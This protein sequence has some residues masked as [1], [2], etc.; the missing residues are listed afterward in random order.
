[1]KLS[2]TSLS[3]FS[4]HKF[5]WFFISGCAR[6]T[7]LLIVIW[8]LLWVYESADVSYISSK[9]NNLCCA[10]RTAQIG[11][12][13]SNWILLFLTTEVFLV[14]IELG[15][16]SF[17]FW[18]ISWESSDGHGQE[19]WATRCYL[20]ERILGKTVLCKWLHVET[21]WVHIHAVKN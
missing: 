18:E 21:V 1:M 15:E 14:T 13:L 3:N 6:S 5:R 20:A 16:I 9:L 12:I 11:K 17:P 8:W 4:L 2:P 10:N 7:R 19:S